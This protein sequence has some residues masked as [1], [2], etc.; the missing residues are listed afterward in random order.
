MAKTAGYF[1]WVSKQA[2]RLRTLPEMSGG[3]S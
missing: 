1:D 3:V 2:Y